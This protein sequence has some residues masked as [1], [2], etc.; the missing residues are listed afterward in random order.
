M[1]LGKNNGSSTGIMNG[2]NLPD[3][4][5]SIGLIQHSSFWTKQDQQGMELWFSKYLDWLLNSDAGKKESQ[6]INNHGTWYDV[7]ASSTALFLNKTDVAKNIL[8]SSIY[9]LIAVLLYRHG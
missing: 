6:T 5:N 3:I 7:E 9:K 4:I 2:H 1:V 8:Q